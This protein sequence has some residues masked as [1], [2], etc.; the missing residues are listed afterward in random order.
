MISPSIVTMPDGRSLAWSEYGDGGGSP[1]FLFHGWPGSRLVG[2]H[3]D[4]A[5]RRLGVRLVCPDRP[6]SGAS[7]IQERRRILDWPVDVVALADRLRIPRFA[8]A[9]KSAGGPYALACCAELPERVDDC[10]LLASAGELGHPASLRGVRQPNK[11]LWRLARRSALGRRLFV[12]LTEGA[13]RRGS[14]ATGMEPPLAENLRAEMIE[15]YRG[16]RA[17]QL[18]EVELLCRPWGVEANRIR[19]RVVMWHGSE[20]D[21]ASPAGARALAASVPGCRTVWSE[22]SDADHFWTERHAEEVLRD[23]L[24]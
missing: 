14:M 2:R 19:A 18:T 20:D 23:L 4:E 7:T 21:I 1:V 6:G 15:G 8:V 13:V 16:G 17:G 24:G 3:F 9:G 5:A 12:V 22:G 11:F 10:G